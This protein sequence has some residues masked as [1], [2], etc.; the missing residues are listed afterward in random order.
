MNLNPIS[1]IRKSVF[2]KILLIIF[3]LGLLIN[4]LVFGFF[5]TYYERHIQNV[6]HENFKNYFEYI[7]NDIGSPPDTVLARSISERY[8][9]A[10]WYKGNEF[11][12]S[13]VDKS[14]Q[15][16]S[17]KMLRQMQNETGFMQ[18]STFIVKNADGSKFIFWGDF[19]QDVRPNPGF[20]VHLLIILSVLIAIAYFLVR[21]I[22]KPVKLLSKCVE[23]VGR[24]NLENTL[25]VNRKDEL[26]K[27][28]NSFNSMTNRIKEMLRSRDQLLLDVSHELRSP[29]TRIK[30]A[31]E[32]IEDGD[33]KSSIENDVKEIEMMA[34]E[35]LETERLK[36]GHGKLQLEEY[37]V[38]KILE[39]IIIEFEDKKPGVS[40]FKINDPVMLKIDRKRIKIVFRNVIEN[41]FRYSK[42][43][44]NPVEISIKNYNDTV[45][46]IVKDDGIGIPEESISKIFEPFYR[47]DASRSKKTGGY[48]LGLNLC[49]KI[50]AAHNGNIAIKNNSDNGITVVLS[51]PKLSY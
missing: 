18:D 50:M 23:D 43:D 48:G 9:L 28:A 2:I 27:L 46:F 13:T 15:K 40:L 31:L 25:N 16:Q 6:L 4:V 45:E 17:R 12:W 22:F 37:D 35:I 20:I 7:A 19:K 24:G 3:G 26:G 34:T 21:F 11:S 39:E 5:K 49:K 30:M 32:F 44:S 47:V 29:L 42:Y 51:F 33:K 8:S 10:I 1:L 36:A 41:A 38:M 14:S